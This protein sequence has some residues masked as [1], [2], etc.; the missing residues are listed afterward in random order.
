MQTRQ[1]DAE[2]LANSGTPKV[3]DPVGT[4]PIQP[5]EDAVTGDSDQRPT[6]E[7]VSFLILLLRALSAWGT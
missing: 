3:G 2:V 6:E 4:Q 7:R 1:L 5:L